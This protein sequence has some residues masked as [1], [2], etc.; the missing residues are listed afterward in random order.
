MP[1]VT[2][3]V[4]GSGLRA[5]LPT[6]LFAAMIGVV[7]LVGGPRLGWLAGGATTAPAPAPDGGVA[8]EPGAPPSARFAYRLTRVVDEGTGT[9]AGYQDAL[10]A[11]GSYEITPA[12]G[13]LAIEASYR[14]RYQGERC[15][16][17]EETRQARASLSD[18][19][20]VGRTDLD[21][22]D[23][24]P[25]S[26]PL[27]VWLWVSPSVQTG[28]TVRILEHDFTVQRGDHVEI[29]ETIVP[30]FVAETHGETVRD[31]AYGHFRVLYTDSYW[32]DEATGYFLR[33][34]HTEVDDN[35][36]AGFEQREV[37]TVT[38]AS[39]LPE[40]VSVP[41]H[42][43]ARCPVVQHEFGLRHAERQRIV[44]GGAVA[45]SRG[46]LYVLYRL[47]RP[48]AHRPTVDGHEVEITRI[49]RPEEL[50]ASLALGSGPLA[51][52]VPHL[53]RVALRAGEDVRVA[54][55][56]ERV[57]GVGIADEVARTA[58][59]FAPHADACE[60]LR[61]DLG[62]TEHFTGHR[63][64]SLP[65]VVSAARAA[66]TS[67]ATPGYN[68]VETYVVL[69]GDT[70]PSPAYDAT[71][72]NR[73]TTEDLPA[74]AELSQRVTG[75]KREAY[76]E[77][78][79]EEG[80]VA[81]VARVKGRIVGAVYLSVAGD[82]AR[83]SQLAVEPS[84]R[85]KGVGAELVRAAI[86]HAAVLGAVRIVT[87]IPPE[88][89]GVRALLEAQGLAATGS[90]FLESAAATRTERTSAWR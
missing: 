58:A 50:P 26:T 29:G 57:I 20:Y 75:H 5:P 79:L 82:R 41:N 9:Y 70:K 31:D 8:A 34:E 2:S 60:L 33:S 67:E 51:A 44:G 30:A 1:A 80:V 18:R 21:D 37:A 63:H 4:R 62:V 24:T 36:E 46:V 7:T 74:L 81:L 87:E 54:R 48:R 78:M 27:G 85:G 45:V 72:V 73:A 23:E 10:V 28:E 22:Y 38:S 68:L 84:A 69:E 88:G 52:F 13:A 53:A 47:A 65:S 76:R 56:G 35:D 77:A 61:R 90:L 40:D 12:D 83:L 71:L 43:V 64:E 17:G 89:V 3:S 39:Y 66:G 59:I 6:V 11:S 42:P 55:S 16:D 15:E 25:G 86:S 49:R 19:L 14:W 32:F